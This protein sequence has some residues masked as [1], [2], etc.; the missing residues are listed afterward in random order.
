M[1]R[2]GRAPISIP[3]GVSLDINGR[4]IT[5]KGSKGELSVKVPSTITVTV[6]GDVVNVTRANEEKQTKA[7]HGLF[8][9]LI[10]NSI[11]G[12]TEGFTKKLEMVGTGYRVKKQGTKLVISAGY[13]HPVEFEA[14]EGVT[15]DTEGD[16]VIVVSGIDKQAV[17][18]AAADIRK[19][20]KPEPYKGKGIR[21]QGE[22][23]IR[24]AGKT[25]A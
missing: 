8:N 18:Q 2:V 10:T 19:V 13:S 9:R 21:Y 6:D 1:S 24:K 11:T 15:L 23:I 14:P 12:V 17:G 7:F 25:A 5:V 16:T 3:S 4:D 20:R 22:I